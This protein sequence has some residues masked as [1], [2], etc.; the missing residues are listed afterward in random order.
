MLVKFNLCFFTKQRLNLY[1]NTFTFC[2]YF[3]ATDTRVVVEYPVKADRADTGV[4]P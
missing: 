3:H 4:A 2:C 1:F